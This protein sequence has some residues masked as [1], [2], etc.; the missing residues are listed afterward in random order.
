MFSQH[1]KNLHPELAQCIISTNTMFEVGDEL[2]ISHLMQFGSLFWSSTIP[3]P[4]KSNL[5]SGSFHV[6]WSEMPK[7]RAHTDSNLTDLVTGPLDLLTR[8]DPSI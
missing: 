2:I 4:K 5:T 8:N 1:D 3:K 7:V 6:I